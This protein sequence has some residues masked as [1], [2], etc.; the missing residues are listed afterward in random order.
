MGQLSLQR[1]LLIEQGRPRIKLI[2]SYQ[3][4]WVGPAISIGDTADRNGWANYDSW[5]VLTLDYCGPS[6]IYWKCWQDEQLGQLSLQRGLPIEK[7]RPRI[8][9]IESCQKSWVGPVTSIGGTVDV[10]GWAN[11]DSPETLTIDCC[12]PSE[13]E[14]QCCRHEWLG[15][16]SLQRVLPI[17]QGRPKLK[18]IESCQTSWVGPVLF[19]GDTLDMMDGSIMI[20]QKFQQ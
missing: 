3:M 17:E 1:G 2:E 19:I 10:N 6:E 4:S 16:L 13:I 8:K 7:G 9:L 15:Q 20:A 14:W 12:G 18:L 11:Y 5:E